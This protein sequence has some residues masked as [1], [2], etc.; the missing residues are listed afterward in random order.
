VVIQGVGHGA[1]WQGEHGG[2]QQ[3]G[4]CFSSSFMWKRDETFTSV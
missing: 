3:G 1:C 2:V 4:S